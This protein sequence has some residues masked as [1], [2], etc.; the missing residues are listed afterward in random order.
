[1]EMTSTERLKAMVCE[2]VNEVAQLDGAL[3]VRAAKDMLVLAECVAAC[4]T[5][6]LLK[7]LTLKRKA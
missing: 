1:M 2:L 7:N 5:G 3:N 4:L 6:F